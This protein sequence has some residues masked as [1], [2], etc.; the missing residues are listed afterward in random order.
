MADGALWRGRVG[1]EAGGRQLSAV[2]LEHGL[3]PLYG[4]GAQPHRGAAPCRHLKQTHQIKGIVQPFEL[5]S[6]TRLIRS[7]VK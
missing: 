6:E 3:D 5:G 1:R 4:L 2:L 7:A